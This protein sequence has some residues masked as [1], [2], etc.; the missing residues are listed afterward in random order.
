MPPP[1]RHYFTQLKKENPAEY[2]RL[3]KLRM[4]NRD[5]F[6]KEMANRLPRQNDPAQEKFREL[7]RKCLE[8]ARRLR[9]EPPPEN[10]DQLREQLAEL[11][12][13]A[14]DTMIQQTQERLEE[15]QARLAQMQ[16]LRD[17]I[18]QQRLDFFLQTPPP[19]EPPDR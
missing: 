6:M 17:R 4:E 3:L 11:V 7:D 8:L 18:V 15:L 16:H 1:V 12:A 5:Q 19:A 2:E 10:A 13:E 9:A 14:V